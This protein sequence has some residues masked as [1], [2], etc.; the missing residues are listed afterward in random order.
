[1]YQAVKDK[2]V[3]MTRDVITISKR[4]VVSGDLSIFLCMGPHIPSIIEVTM[5]I[6]GA[7]FLKQFEY[8]V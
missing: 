4:A 1:M 2:P 6:I 3:R 7:E 5:E 8:S